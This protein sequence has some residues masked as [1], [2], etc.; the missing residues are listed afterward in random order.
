VRNL[1]TQEKKDERRIEAFEIR[2]LLG[3]YEC[4]VQLNGRMNGF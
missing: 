2:R 3:K 1:D 4:D